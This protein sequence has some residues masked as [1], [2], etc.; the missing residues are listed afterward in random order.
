MA[1]KAHEK[2]LD[3]WNG[4]A[5]RARHDYDTDQHVIPEMLHEEYFGWIHY[6]FRKGDI[7]FVTDAAT[8]RATFIIDDVDATFRRVKFSLL[9]THTVA[10]VTKPGENKPDPGMTVRFRGPRGGNWC[11]VSGADEIVSGG[12]RTKLEAEQ[13]LAHLVSLKTEAA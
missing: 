10:P 2:W 1:T 6:R 11:I 13:K 9:R 5:N 8:N 12:H 3:T 4:S 7:L